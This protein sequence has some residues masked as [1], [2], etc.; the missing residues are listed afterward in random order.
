M[1]AA[2][3][4]VPSCINLYLHNYETVYILTFNIPLL[5]TQRK[6]LGSCYCNTSHL[7]IYMYLSTYLSIFYDLP[8]SSLAVNNIMESR[9]NIIWQ[10]RRGLS[11]GTASL[12]AQRCVGSIRHV[13]YDAILLRYAAG[14]MHNTAC[15]ARSIRRF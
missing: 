2:F 3:N 4:R 1:S 8:P 5:V 14:Y 11:A 7:N 10:I 9:L 6:Y 12:A 13:D 15:M